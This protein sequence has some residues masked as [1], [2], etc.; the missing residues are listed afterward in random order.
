MSV[1]NSLKPLGMGTYG[2]V[3]RDKYKDLDVAV[4]I[5]LLDMKKE[6]DILI[7][8]ATLSRSDILRYVNYLVVSSQD[9]EFSN[10]KSKYKIILDHYYD[11]TK[12]GRDDYLDKVGNLEQTKT[13]YI[14]ITEFVDGVN[15]RDAI[16]HQT[17]D[18]RNVFYNIFNA[19]KACHNIGIFHLDLKLENIMLKKTE[20]LFL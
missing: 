19:V 2:V 20:V 13:F 9:K 7:K 11:I 16:I 5:S 4:K 14:L 3:Y 17:F 12:R 18:T 6:V 15:L 8:L 10:F 1:E